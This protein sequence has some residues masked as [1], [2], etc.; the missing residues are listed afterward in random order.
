MLVLLLPLAAQRKVYRDSDCVPDE[1]SGVLSD[2]KFQ[3][4]RHYQ[5]DK[6]AYHAAYAL[7]KQIEFLVG[8]AHGRGDNILECMCMTFS[9]CVYF[10]IAEK[11]LVKG[12]PREYCNSWFLT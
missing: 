8:V 9:L 3:K 12:T 11:T 5:L 4:S 10:E 1:L 2:D 7:F 6:S